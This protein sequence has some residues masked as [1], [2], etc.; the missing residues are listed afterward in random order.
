MVTSSVA[1]S[2]ATPIC[3]SSAA[4]SLRSAG[5]SSVSLTRISASARL[6]KRSRSR[7]IACAS[8][9]SATAPGCLRS[10]NLIPSTDMVR[11]LTKRSGRARIAA[12]NASSDA[13]CSEIRLR[14][15]RRRLRKA[16]RCSALMSSAS[17]SVAARAAAKALARATMSSIVVRDARGDVARDAR[18]ECSGGGATGAVICFSLSCISFFSSAGAARRARLLSPTSPCPPPPKGGGGTQAAP[19]IS[20]SPP[21]GEERAGVRWVFFSTELAV[22]EQA[23]GHRVAPWSCSP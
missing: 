8:S 5:R 1:F 22:C 18:G 14:S 7:L 13:A 12:R 23:R 19:T 20:P 9:P 4:G 2:M 11:G 6:G 3:A 17:V 10:P 21:P 15:A 16:L